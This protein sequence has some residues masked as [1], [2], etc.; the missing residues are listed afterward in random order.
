MSRQELIESLRRRGEEQVREIWRQAEAEARRLRTAAE[1]RLERER[2]AA[3]RR[4]S[5]AA[6]ESARLVQLEAERR[7]RQLLAEA[8]RAVAERLNREAKAALGTLRDEENERLFAVLAAELPPGDWREVTVCPADAARAAQRF[9]QARII[10]DPAVGG[11]LEATAAGGRIR[12]VNTLE[13]RLERAWDD[14]LPLLLQEVLREA[15]RR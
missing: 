15:G 10:S 11:G 13:R 3:S 2:E 12:V 5:A 9:P 8:K 6:T 4:R 1:Q 14:L 7:A